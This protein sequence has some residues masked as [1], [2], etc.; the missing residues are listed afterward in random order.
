MQRQRSILS[1]FQKPTAATT[2]GLV[3]G[4]A[5]SGGG[6]SGG[7]RFN[8][9]EGDAKGDASVRFAVSK[10]VDEVR[11]TDTPPE[12]VPRRVLPSGFKPAES[13]GDASSLFSNIMHKFVKVDDRDCSGERSREDVVP[14]NDSS[15]CMKANDVIP[16]FRSNNGKTQERNHAFSFSGRA[17]LRS[18]EDIG[19]DGDV[20]G[21]ETPGMRP[22]ASRLKR[23][24]EDEMTFK[25]DKVPVLDSNKR[26]KMLQ[27]PVC[28]EKK[29][30]NEGTKFEWLES[31]RIRDANRRRPDDPLYDRKTL[32]IPPDVFKKMSASQKQYWSVKSEYM[33]IV[34]FFKVGK[35]YELYE[36]D[37]ELGHKELDWKMTM[38]GVGKCRQVGISESGIDE[39]VQKL[40]ARGYKV[41]RIE[42]L[43]TSDQAK[44]RGANTI[45]PRKLV[46]VLTPSTAS[47]GNIGPDAVH[48]LAIKEIK[49][50]LQKC[51]TV[52]GFA[53]VDC[54]ALRF[55]VGSISDDASCA[56]L[57]ALLMQVSPKEVLYDSK[58]LSREAQKALRKYTLTGSTAVQLAPVPQVMG[59][60]D[61]AGV[62]NI[63]ESNGYFKGSSESWNCAVDGLN[64]C[65]VALS[66]L[67][68]LI[69][70]L[71]RLKLE[72]VLKHGDIFPYQ[73]YRG[74][75][76][77]DGQTMVNLEIFNNSCDGGPS[78]TLYKY[79]DNCV[80]P[81][82]KRLLRNWIC[83]PLK[84]VESINKRLDVV[85]EFTANS[86][87]MQIT[88]QYLHKLPDLE[89]LLGRI[90]SSVRSSAS[91]LPALLGKKVLKQRVKAF[92]QIVK[93]FRSGIDLLLALQK[94]SNMMSLL[95]KLCKLP[96]LVGK[97]GLELFLSQFEAA[98]DSDFPNYQNQDV[99]DENA[100][101]L[102]ILIELFIERATQW[103]EV[104]HTISCLDVLRSFAIA[105]SL[106][107]GSMA[108]P[109]IFPESE[110]TD[111]NQKTK[112]PILKI[113]GLWH[114]F[115]VAA[116]GQLPVP[117]DIL[118]G[119]AR[120]SSGSIHPRSLLLTGPNMGGKSTLL[121]ATCLAVIFAQ[122]GCYVP[123]ESC[124]ISLVDTIFT[125]LGASDR[126]MTGE[127]TFLVECTE[128]AS[129]LQNAT[130]DS[131]VI[132]DE[133]GR[134][135][136][137]FDG[138]AIAY[139]V[140]RHLVEK[141]QCRMLF[142]THYHPL[143]KEFASHPRVTSK[144]MACAFKSRSDYQ[145][146]G[147]DQDLVFLYRLTEGAC[148]ESY[149]LQVALMAGI[150]NQVVETASGA[151][152][153]MKRSIGENFKSSELRSEFSSLHEDW[154][155]S[156]VGISRVAHNN[157]PIG[158]DD[159]DTLFCLWHEIKS[160][161]C[162]PK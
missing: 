43:E 147:C 130:Q 57:G 144:H 23:V 93:G 116:D 44:A 81:T 92:G 119:E 78:G 71:S 102:T 134:G 142:A 154:L 59:D 6:G 104:I 39:A 37:A 77:I 38:S 151:A 27:D 79:L 73:V 15:L 158:E 133:L 149:G 161:Y 148:P 47:E 135:T 127:S 52:Y 99:T 108:R 51:S 101:T 115:A 61:A 74:C 75:L 24:L 5:A 66:A 16:Q 30:V 14:L 145:P 25:E 70:H 50:E 56:A 53:F 42:Q 141:V 94:E 122:L 41:G 155:K 58:G 2:K 69:N 152:Q 138:Y 114:P 121:R 68:E 139:S 82:G 34:L 22:R 90:K 55:W 84:D 86:E 26:L 8:V 63:I 91:V 120:R 83:H 153:A 48:L 129:V 29:E 87:S 7:P 80:S 89:R 21:P 65:D 72:D 156:L 128:T 13:A 32:H 9:K 110:A 100:E 85:E 140:F 106:S 118:L 105:A 112:G 40:L 124:E 162:V 113:Q 10:S 96:I 36:L 97:S 157:A 49:M 146:R 125:R 19:V 126:I 54:A 132:L 150:P 64:E 20:P 117:N 28:G 98:I 160:S 136:S 111:Q 76:R 88:G 33:D 31:S 17:E 60:T 159:Y 45:I 131:L 95:Y 67:G 4:D 109:V 35:F 137:T 12:K 123:C 18:V 3:S 1:F 103:S 107:A 62:R 143:T 46:Q 11:G